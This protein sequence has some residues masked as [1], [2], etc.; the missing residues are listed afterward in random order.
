MKYAL[1]SVVLLN[2]LAFSCKGK[3]EEPKK[4]QAPPP[5]TVDVI[6][7][8]SQTIPNTIE[9]N[10][11]VVAGEF[12][13]VRPEISGR[14]TYLNVA[15]G[16][17][18]TRGSVIAKINDADLRAQLNKVKVQLQLAEITVARYKKLLDIQGINRADYD[19]ALNQVN[20]LKADIGIIQADLAKTVV[21]SPFSGV[22]GLR[23]VSN[24]AYV[25][26]ATILATLQQMGKIR[27]DFTLPE[28]YANLLKRG[29]KVVVETDANAQSK[30]RATIIA[31]EPQISTTTR[32]VLVRARLDDATNVNPGSF[33]KVYVD[34]GEENGM[35]IP[36]NAIIPDARAKQVVVVKGGKAKFVDIETG[37][38][39]VGA[40]QV[41]SGLNAGDSVVISG[42]LFARPNAA[43]KVRKVRTLAEVIK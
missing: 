11:T 43:V 14:L 31:I 6:I 15:E 32:N 19:V 5:P 17:R 38:R 35:M 34:A 36:A 23:Q 8:S 4:N 22:V 27:I 18:I 25:T 13:E 9:A 2:L 28:N 3:K 29:N 42:V 16:S 7:A 10:G 33:V 41:T 26:P 37:V 39:Q 20:S 30:R 21:R 24:G 1:L 12:V 40:V